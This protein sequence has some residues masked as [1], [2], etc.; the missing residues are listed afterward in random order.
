MI[1]K[2]TCFCVFSFI[3][4]KSRFEKYVFINLSIAK[5][6]ILSIEDSG[7]FEEVQQEFK[8]NSYKG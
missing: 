3:K 7:F 5:I 2:S 4:D 1:K 8:I 6:K